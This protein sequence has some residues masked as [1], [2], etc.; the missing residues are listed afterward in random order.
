MVD[1]IS[2]LPE[3]IKKRKK[4]THTST[5]TQSPVQAQ[6][7]LGRIHRKLV[8]VIMLLC[9]GLFYI[10]CSSTQCMFYEYIFFPQ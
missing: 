9:P 10:Q 3:Y 2:T 5:F 8:S 1:L 7:N 6:T 4:F